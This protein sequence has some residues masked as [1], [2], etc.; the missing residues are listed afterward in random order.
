VHHLK[1]PVSDLGRGL[2]W[3]EATLG[4]RRIERFDHRDKDGL[5]YAYIIQLPGLDVPVEL[6]LA[7]QAA[8]AVAGYDPVTLGVADRAE[9][10]LWIAH[11]DAIGQP[12]SP[13]V[14]GYIGDVMEIESPDGLV[15]RL[16][17]D[18]AGGFGEAQFDPES[19]DTD[20]P[21]MNTPLMQRPR[22]AACP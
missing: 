14:S 2:S 22:K 3:F 16:Y 4:A 17:T 19:A 13:V 1:F 5:L 12:R 21:S 9:L 18:P 15:I 11:F 6:R 20:A 7:P 10:D 8:A